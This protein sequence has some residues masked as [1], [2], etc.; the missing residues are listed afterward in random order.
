[1]GYA[2]DT[3]RLCQEINQ[4]RGARMEMRG[5]LNRF[6]AELRRNMNEQRSAMRRRNAEEAARTKTALASFVSNIRQM[7]RETMGSFEHERQAAHGA[8]MR[9]PAARRH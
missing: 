3:S 5:R 1:M 7:M 2:D 4:M 9:M 6:A 8:W